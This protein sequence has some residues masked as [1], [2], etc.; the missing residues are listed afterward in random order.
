MRISNKMMLIPL[1]GLIIISAFNTFIIMQKRG[2]MTSLAT[3]ADISLTVLYTPVGYPSDFTIFLNKDNF[4]VDLNWTDVPEADDYNVY[5]SSNLSD[6]KTIGNSVTKVTGIKDSNWTDTNAGNVRQRYY[7]V[8][9]VKG[10][11]TNI[12]P[13]IEGKFDIE[14]RKANL[15]YGY[16]EMNTV[17]LPLIPS[18]D[19]ITNIVIYG[20]NYDIINWYNTT[21]KDY[22]EAYYYE[23]NWYGDFNILEPGK[24]YEFTP[25]NKSYN[26][27]VVGF[28]PGD[29]ITSEIQ[30][31]TLKAGEVEINTIGWNTPLKRCNFSTIIP[32]ATNF[33]YIQW[34][35]VSK[36]IPSFD[37]AY[38]YNGLWYGKIRCF[39]PGRGYVFA[40]ISVGYNWTYN[41]SEGFS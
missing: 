4:S 35:N 32:I 31:A 36:K 17:S 25:I 37:Y 1:L 10:A 7:R 11:V 5:Y 22:D 30:R 38:Y 39:D 3:Q 14:I 12:T 9:A 16:V 41:R 2:A 33:D 6:L 20:M 21:K 23:G 8:A 28:V 29:N 40:P 13:I 26:F 24:G 27:T 34:Y 15:T 18:D 19:N